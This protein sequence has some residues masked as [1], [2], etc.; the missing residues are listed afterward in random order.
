MTDPDAEDCLRLFEEIVA[1]GRHLAIMGHYSHP[2]ELAPE[3]AKEAVRRIRATGAEIRMQAP[4]IRHV[5]DDPMLWADLWRE[6]VKLGMIPYYMFIE[7]DTGAK[8]TSKYPWR[9][10]MKSTRTLSG[11]ARGWPEPLGDHRCQRSRAR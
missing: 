7:R 1:A 5:N 11:A 6:G 9:A 3:V 4:L 2:A 10:A 8:N